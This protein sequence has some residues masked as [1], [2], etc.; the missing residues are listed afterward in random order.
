M[1]LNVENIKKVR[2]VIAALPRARF[3]MSR[4]AWRTDGTSV[5]TGDAVEVLEHD[6]GTAGCIGGWTEAIFGSPGV[7]GWCDEEVA[8][9]LGLG[10]AEGDRLFY[11]HDVSDRTQTE[12][13]A[14]LD[15]LIETGEVNWEWA[16]ANPAQ[17][18]GAS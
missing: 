17:I 1:S 11:P 15:R 8:A 12:A 4:W 5:T 6:C 2:D 13:V 18:G 7:R 3:D 10:G 16:I 14:V 9:L